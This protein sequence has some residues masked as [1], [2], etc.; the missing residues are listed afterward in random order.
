MKAGPFFHNIGQALP[1][2]LR[3]LRVKLLHQDRNQWT[4]QVYRG[5]MALFI[6][7]HH[8]NEQIPT[9]R[10]EICPFHHRIHSLLHLEQTVPSSMPKDLDWRCR[11]LMSL[12]MVE[13]RQLT[14]HR[15]TL[16]MPQARIRPAELALM[17]LILPVLFY[18]L[19]HQ[20]LVPSSV[21]GPLGRQIRSLGLILPIKLHS[22]ATVILKHQFLLSQ[23]VS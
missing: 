13:V 1:R 7:L 9:T 12:L 18:H 10:T 23:A 14:R 11:S 4:C 15:T 20:V 17:G 16:L 19:L 8:R 2:Q 21:R 3:H 6:L 22:R 5:T